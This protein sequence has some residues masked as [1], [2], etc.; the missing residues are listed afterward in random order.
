MT[1]SVEALRSAL[2]AERAKRLSCESDLSA[3]R[4]QAEAAARAAQEKIAEYDGAFDSLV[5]ENAVLQQQA[6]AARRELAEA[7]R[8]SS[9]AV[10]VQQLDVI[11]QLET[12]RAEASAARRERDDL[13]LSFSDLQSR[14]SSLQLEMA[15]A[16]E[17][18]R[19]D[20]A[21]LVEGM[22]E[23]TE[24]IK[25]QALQSTEAL[26]QEA[27]TLKDELTAIQDKLHRMEKNFQ[28]K[29]SEVDSLRVL[30]HATKEK[31]HRSEEVRMEAEECLSRVQ[32]KGAQR[33]QQ[34]RDE[35]DAA[36]EE[37]RQERARLF[38]RIEELLQREVLSRNEIERLSAD[39]LVAHSE[40][41]GL[42]DKLSKASET[43]AASFGGAVVTSRAVSDMLDVCGERDEALDQLQLQRF[44]AEEREMALK[45]DM[46]EALEGFRADRA[47]LLQ[48]FE[49]RVEGAVAEKNAELQQARGVIAALG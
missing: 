8:E 23:S 1:Q 20:R 27:E 26:F 22:R 4:E 31:L 21:L 18:F 12:T 9:T 32:V 30:L 42:E 39:V 14:Y 47:L 3:H 35:M 17:G 2:E 40:I 28:G 49:S 7:S 16:L 10:L 48:S 44:Q 36:L 19:A 11:N 24:R 29:S 15:E 37:F 6:D 46:E 41:K 13:R 38:Q 25:S 34:L 5:A 45:A 33:E 43:T